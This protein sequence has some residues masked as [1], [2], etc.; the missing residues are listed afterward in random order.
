MST[1]EDKIQLKW[2]LETKERFSLSNRYSDCHWKADHYILYLVSDSEYI[3][4]AGF[5]YSFV[6]ESD[7]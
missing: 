1:K 3:C 7:V 2:L 6:F 5:F 4:R